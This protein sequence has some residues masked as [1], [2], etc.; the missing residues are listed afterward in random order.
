[1]NRGTLPE[2]LKSGENMCPLCHPVPMSM[3]SSKIRYWVLNK[4]SVSIDQQAQNNASSLDN[5][6]FLIILDKV[7]RPILTVK[8]TG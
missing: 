8:H 7:C 3:I 2:S 1:M 4:R 6:S 5:K